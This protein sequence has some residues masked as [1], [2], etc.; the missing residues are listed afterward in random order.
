MA[1]L[2]TFTSPKEE[3]KFDP[4]SLRVGDLVDARDGVGKWC[5]ST[6]MAI[7]GAE[8]LIHY[9]GWKSK[10]LSMREEANAYSG[11]SGL[12]TWTGSLPKTNIHH[13]V[14]ISDL[15]LYV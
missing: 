8:V 3:A 7:R 5:E 13:L 9:N 15:I 4:L 1:P 12:A 14:T 2:N 10:V 6:V 11:M